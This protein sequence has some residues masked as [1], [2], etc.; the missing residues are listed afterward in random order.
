[1][2]VMNEYYHDESLPE[3]F[4]EALG[5]NGKALQYWSAMTPQERQERTRAVSR[6]SRPEEIE[7]YVN[8]M[9]GWE[10]GHPPYQE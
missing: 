6:L 3:G 1:M 5:K 2:D 4:R 9:V 10:I 8:D 7:A